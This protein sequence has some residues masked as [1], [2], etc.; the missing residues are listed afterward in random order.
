MIFLNW[1]SDQ[2]GGQYELAV[3]HFRVKYWNIFL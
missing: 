1:K 3:S 2:R